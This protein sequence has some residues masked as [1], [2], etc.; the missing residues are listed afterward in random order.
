VGRYR[1]IEMNEPH[2]YKSVR[3]PYY[4]Y[5][6]PGMY[7]VTLCVR[8]REC[9]FGKIENGVMILNEI[10]AL[11]KQEWL[12]SAEVRREL[13]LDEFIIMPN[14]LHGIVFINEMEGKIDEASRAR[15]LHRILE[16]VPRRGS[17][18]RS[19]RSLSSFVA[20]FKAYS[21]KVVNDI[22]H[23]P[24]LR[25]WQPS[26]FEYVIRD[27]KGLTRMRFYV[28]ENPARWDRD[29]ENPERKTIRHRG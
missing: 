7:S 18:E 14:H 24:G 17:R 29:I 27:E 16:P 19:P 3:L 22:R 6:S 8:Q 4:D 26:F 2:K 20:G 23:T 25:L 11:V 15:A 9:I 13:T 10:G 1:A 12:R 5:A 21:N 28:Q